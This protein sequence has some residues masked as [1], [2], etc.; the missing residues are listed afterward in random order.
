M[1]R[2]EEE[3]RGVGRSGEEWGRVGKSE[4]GVRRSEEE[5]GGSEE[6]VRRE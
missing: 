6:G 3:L 1:K 2:S 5:W 4:E